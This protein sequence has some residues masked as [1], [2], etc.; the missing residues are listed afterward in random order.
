[1]NLNFFKKQKKE[2]HVLEDLLYINCKRTHCI[3]CP[4]RD[5]RYLCNVTYTWSQTE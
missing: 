2:K 3:E 4:Y 5:N 1:M